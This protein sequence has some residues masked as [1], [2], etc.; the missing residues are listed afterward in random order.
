MLNLITL[1]E[2]LGNSRIDTAEEN[3]YIEHLIA[4]AEGAVLRLTN[5]TIEDFIETY[6]YESSEMES[7]KH[8]ML[9]YVD[10]LYKHRGMTENVAVQRNPAFVTLIRPL[11][12]L[13]RY[14]I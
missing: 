9:M 7:L 8:A 5:R 12:K 1:E 14:G 6:G 13:K 10:D 2:V 11:K 4:V 3:A